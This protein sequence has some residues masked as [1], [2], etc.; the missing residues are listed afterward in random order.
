MRRFIFGSL[1]LAVLAFSAAPAQAALIRLTPQ[2]LSPSEY[3]AAGFPT[4]PAIIPPDGFRLTYH[5]G[6]AETLVNPILLILG[7]PTGVVA[8]SHQ[9]RRF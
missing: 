5:G 4:D 2:G 7:I 9:H 1:V 6:G 8:W 3:E